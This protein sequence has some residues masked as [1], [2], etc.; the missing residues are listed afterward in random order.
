MLA[1]CTLARWSLGSPARRLRDCIAFHLL[2]H[3]SHA[4]LCCVLSAAK[5]TAEPAEPAE[6]KAATPA[7]ARGRA[8]KAPAAVSP[9]MKRGLG[10]HAAPS[11]S[12]PLGT[13]SEQGV[14]FMA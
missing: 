7:K 11:T 12:A 13:V 6:K 1:R 10:G 5:R 14:W 8:G 9:S 2:C 4:L 3:L